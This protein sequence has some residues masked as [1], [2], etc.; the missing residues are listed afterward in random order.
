MPEE[1]HR[2]DRVERAAD[3][4]DQQQSHTDQH[5]EEIREEY[6]YEEAPVLRRRAMVS[7]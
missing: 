7:V 4:R 6:R 3:H 5:H 2:T 1:L